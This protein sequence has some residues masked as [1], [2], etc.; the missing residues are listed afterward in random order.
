MARGGSQTKLT[1]SNAT[2]TLA[3]GYYLVRGATT[4]ARNT[5]R[6]NSNENPT[7][8]VLES[9]CECLWAS[10]HC[11]P[12]TRVSTCARGGRLPRHRSHAT[13]PRSPCLVR[14]A[15][16]LPSAGLFEPIPHA[17]QQPPSNPR[18]GQ[19]HLAPLLPGSSV[20]SNRSICETQRTAGQPGTEMVDA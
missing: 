3:S 18:R 17:S 10:R 19:P 11:A 6:Y 14:L 7:M 20:T 2:E 15:Q 5:C 1:K 12:S 16:Q 4:L 9:V 13:Q 8:R